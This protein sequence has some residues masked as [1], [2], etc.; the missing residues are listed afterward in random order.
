MEMIGRRSFW[1]CRL[2]LMMIGIIG[3]WGCDDD[4]SYS[5]LTWQDP[6]SPG[7]MTWEE[8]KAYC[9]NL[10]FDGHDDWRLPTIS[11]LR[12]L[13]RGCSDTQTGGACSVTDDRLEFSWRNNPCNGCEYG[14]GPGS[15][16]AYWPDSLSGNDWFWS[17]S[18]VADFADHAWGVEFYRGS[19]GYSEIDY[20]FPARC[21]RSRP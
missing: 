16:G 15:E 13:I 11:E 3:V 4:D 21:V 19:V 5:G 8:A 7:D 6:P 2:A 10:S 14:A 12:S 17:S 9:D 1:F 20:P 18:E